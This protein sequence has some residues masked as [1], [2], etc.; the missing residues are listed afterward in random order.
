MMRG[1]G[2]LPAIDV[3]E[4]INKILNY[5][6]QIQIEWPVED[7]GGSNGQVLLE[8]GMKYKFTATIGIFPVIRSTQW[9]GY[10][11]FI[12]FS[13]TLDDV[14][15]FKE[16][17]DYLEKTEAVVEFQPETKTKLLG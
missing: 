16:E 8:P 3:D 10:S 14:D 13:T 5:L 9:F 12:D 17:L 2:I 15:V 1:F 7:V 4:E 11:Y 6:D